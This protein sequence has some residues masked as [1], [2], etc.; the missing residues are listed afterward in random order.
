LNFGLSKIIKQMVASY[1]ILARFE[2]DSAWRIQEPSI[3]LINTY[4]N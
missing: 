3:F 4:I 2:Y 1:D